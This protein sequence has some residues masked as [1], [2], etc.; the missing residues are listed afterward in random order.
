MLDIIRNKKYEMLTF[1]PF[2][3]Y[4][5]KLEQENFVLLNDNKKHDWGELLFQNDVEFLK[6][7]IFTDSE[8]EWFSIYKFKE[9]DYNYMKTEFI[10]YNEKGVKFYQPEYN[11]IIKYASYTIEGEYIKLITSGFGYHDNEYDAN[12]GWRKKRKIEATDLSKIYTCG[13][14]LQELTIRAEEANLDFYEAID[15]KNGEV[16]KLKL[17]YDE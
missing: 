5:K 8:K 10:L 17:T 1:L 2:I 12:S 16:K 15:E 7:L 6:I 4:L 3:E 13:M 14:N 11:R 9:Q